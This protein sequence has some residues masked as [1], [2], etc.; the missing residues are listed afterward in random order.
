MTKR[1]SAEELRFLRRI[2]IKAKCWFELEGKM[3]FG[4]GKARLF[5]MIARYGSINAGARAMGIS[6]RQAWEHIRR[7]EEALAVT[8][9]EKHKGGPGGGGSR[10]TPAGERL[11]QIYDALSG[12]L[13]KQAESSFEQI[14]NKKTRK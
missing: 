7:I 8:L 3:F 9:V 11:L 2:R 4:A 13:K 12:R 14:L 6:Y 1:I 5:R 10:I